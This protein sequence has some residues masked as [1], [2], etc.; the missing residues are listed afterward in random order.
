MISMNE[1]RASNLMLAAGVTAMAA[2]VGGCQWLALPFLLW[3]P[4]PTRKIA[5]EYPYLAGKKVAIAVWAEPDTLYEFP[6]VQYEL[7]EHVAREIQR[8]VHTVTFIPNRRVRDV[9]A[10]DPDWDRMHPAVLGARFGAERTLLIEVTQYTTRDPDSP[11]LYLG[12]ISANVRVYNTAY[13]KALSAKDWVVE[14]VYPPDGPGRWGSSDSS[15]RAG[16]MQAFAEQ[17]ARKFY[18]HQIKVR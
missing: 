18:D 4:E 5:A 7:A 9:Q 3:A 16:V 11:H 1:R 15:I 13:P 2:A 10:G 14:T 17:T 6:H 8:H 12:R